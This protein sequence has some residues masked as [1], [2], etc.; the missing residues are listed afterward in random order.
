MDTSLLPNKKNKI[1]PN[2]NIKSTNTL[3]SLA[4]TLLYSTTPKTKGKWKGGSCEII[5]RC[6]VI[7]T[8]WH[9]VPV[10]KKQQFTVVHCFWL[11]KL[12]I[13]KFPQSG[14][15]HFC[16][17]HSRWQYQTHMYSA[18]VSL[19]KTQNPCLLTHCKPPLWIWASA[20]C[21]KCKCIP[22]FTPIRFSKK[23]NIFKGYYSVFRPRTNAAET[24]FFSL[25]KMLEFTWYSY[26][27]D[28]YN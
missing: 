16:P 8:D 6:F 13:R 11:L 23:S 19:N 9:Y 10:N 3:S 28:S 17:Q 20:K 27:E 14:R 5:I 15:S 7:L 24:Y 25:T 1:N 21:L 22:F 26:S 2:N 12:R 4:T 18:K